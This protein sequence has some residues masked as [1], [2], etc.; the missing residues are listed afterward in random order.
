MRCTQMHGVLLLGATRKRVLQL[1]TKLD[2][3]MK[4]SGISG[5]LETL[6]TARKILRKSSMVSL[7]GIRS[8]QE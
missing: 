6:K 4:I 8:I 3:W 1:T 5:D 2:I 7:L